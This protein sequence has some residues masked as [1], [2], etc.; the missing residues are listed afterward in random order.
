MIIK[1]Q[2]SPP[3]P[4]WFLTQAGSESVEFF[5]LQARTHTHTKRF[6]SLRRW[7]LKYLQSVALNVSDG[8]PH[9][10]AAA[11][12]NLGG[13]WGKVN[14]PFSIP[15]KRYKSSGPPAFPIFHLKSIPPPPGQRA[16]L[17]CKPWGGSVINLFRSDWAFGS[18]A[19]RCLSTPAHEA[20]GIFRAAVN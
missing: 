13:K 11:V 4:T 17:S 15:P 1:N 12:R 7:F 18:Q 2:I 6:M 20:L 16:Q 9:K 19:P 10:P 3:R 14:R 5:L 8:I